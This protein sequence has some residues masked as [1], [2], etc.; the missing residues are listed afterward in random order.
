MTR[1]F[2][3]YYLGSRK[4]WHIAKAVI[5]EKVFGLFCGLDNVLAFIC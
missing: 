4:E 2:N 5:S 3:S 1:L